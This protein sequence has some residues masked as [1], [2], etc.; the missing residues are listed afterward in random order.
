[1]FEYSAARQLDS[2]FPRRIFAGCALSPKNRFVNRFANLFSYS[3]KRWRRE[4][5]T[6]LA[7]RLGLMVDTPGP[8]PTCPISL[9]VSL[10]RGYQPISDRSILTGQVDT[11]E[12][13]SI[14]MRNSRKFRLFSLH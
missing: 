5:I 9:E 2:Q 8:D 14:S 13:A 12:P 1:M 4:Q 7:P 6:N 11:L 10:V 3:K